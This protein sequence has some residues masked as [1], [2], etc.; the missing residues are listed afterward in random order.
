MA[1]QTYVKQRPR[2]K[3]RRST[4]YY[5]QLSKQLE[6]QGPIAPEYAATTEEGRWGMWNRWQKFCD[7]AVKQDPL[8]YLT[9]P[10]AEKYMVF[11]K[12]IL[13]K[14]PNVRKGHSLETYWKQFKGAYRDLVLTSMDPDISKQVL[15]Y[16]QYRL[17]R[18]YKLDVSQPQ[19]P[20]LEV[21][22]FLLVL[23]HH[24][25]QDTSVYPC[26][27]QRLQL[28]LLLLFAAYTGTRP[29][30]LLQTKPSKQQLESAPKVK[31]AYASQPDVADITDGDPAALEDNNESDDVSESESDHGGYNGAADGR[32]SAGELIQSVLYQHVTILVVKHKGRDVLT[33][34][35]TLVHTKGENRKPQPVYQH[36]NPL[37]CPVTY[38]IALGLYNNA[39]AASS[40]RDPKDVLCA[41]VPQRKNSLALRW[42]ESKLN[43][44]I[45]QEYTASESQIPT[46]LRGH[47]AR[48]WIK[49]LGESVGLEQPLSQYCIRRATGN[50]V[51]D[52]AT[53][54]ER[55][56]IMGHAN[57]NIFQFYIN[58]KVKCDVQAAFLEEP[59]DKTLM[60]VLG[61]MALTYD[62][63]APRGLSE[64]DACRISKH[65]T[66]AKL[67]RNRDD[68][69]TKIRD[70]LHA[71]SP[72]VSEN[73]IEQLDKRRK[74]LNAR[75]R[76][77]KKQLRDRA[78]RV[79][80]EVYFRE[81]DTRE[82][83]GEL[84]TAR[85]PDSEG[86]PQRPDYQLQER[87][88]IAELLC[89][90][91]G[92]LSESD[93]VQHRL[94]LVRALTKLCSRRE[95]R[96]RN[97]VR[98]ASGNEASPKQED[99]DEPASFPLRCDT[100]QCLFC[101]GDERLPVRQR[102]FRWC[103]PAKM[104]DHVE[105]HLKQYTL[106]ARI[107]CPHP[108]CKADGWA[109]DGVL[110]FHRHAHTV[111]GIKHRL[112]KPLL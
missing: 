33:M 98:Y 34:S 51:D 42:K 44:P 43:E 60:R 88:H 102:R 59:S 63:Y 77:K 65:P 67:R 75:L 17:M 54:A 28:A 55:D 41:Q 103:R 107:Y 4:T 32:D 15:R 14:Y 2:K 37:L 69:T 99:P 10:T 30:S 22:A 26:E 21:D 92:D 101:L 112:P 89:R 49:R 108:I 16:I 110:H 46:P 7:S 53:V 80:R 39:F 8:A 31:A 40:I 29:C 12:W 18:E 94:E 74:E 93:Q 52:V 82:L 96:R 48:N 6:E 19:R 109:L 71:P 36:S 91:Y 23:H 9:P 66:I 84:D 83:D 95:T 73:A 61:S 76:R 13:D 5:T 90:P 105:G 100:R 64:E 24:W 62:P 111:H 3:I 86:E 106:N 35:I 11:M 104:M 87:A 97:A 81:N 45:F 79:A 68:M 72:T 20:V 56:Q 50:A 38:M 78:E 1:H 57:S 70:L 27:E 47:T 58:P 25:V 85:L